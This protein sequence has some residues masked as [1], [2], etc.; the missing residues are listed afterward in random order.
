MAHGYTFQDSI[1][2]FASAIG[3]SGLSLG[4]TGPDAPRFILWT[5][6]AGMLLGTFRNI[7]N[8]CCRLKD[9]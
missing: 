3:T 7:C 5:E 9:H 4:I 1:F 8:L 6:I 2:E